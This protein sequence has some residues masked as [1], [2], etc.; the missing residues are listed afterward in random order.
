[1]VL[2]VLSIYL[3]I[4]KFYL[5]TF[6][7][8]LGLFLIFY[9]PA[10]FLYNIENQIE[11]NNANTS[12]SILTLFVIFYFAGSSF[13]KQGRFVNDYANWYNKP[14]DRVQ[15]NKGIL[16]VFSLFTALIIY[17]GLFYGGGI[18][19][20]FTV[21]TQDVTPDD[22][23]TLRT[24]SGVSGP[25][26][27]IFLY[28]SP[29]LGKFVVLLFFGY[30]LDSKNK[31]LIVLAFLFL[32]LIA[33][34]QLANLSKSG[35]IFF[36]IQIIFFISFYKNVKINLT[37][38]LVFFIF[39]IVLFVFIYLEVTVAENYTMALAEI[40]NRI[41]GEPTRV[42]NLY[43]STWPDLQNYTMG[44]N[45]RFAHLLFGSG[46]YQSAAAKLCGIPGCTYNMMFIGDAWVDFSYIGVI[47]QSFIVGYF[48]SYLDSYIFNSKNYLHQ[49]LFAS[50]VSSLLALISVGLVTALVTYGL[51]TMPLLGQF[52]KKKYVKNSSKNINQW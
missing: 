8:Y 24:E 37:K 4:N 5:S 27:D 28:L 18:N 35:F 2:I 17:L 11:V 26:S 39:I 32:A 25:V 9:G 29:G 19:S 12:A 36:I 13:F 47:T 42:L 45:I 50:L 10:F 22:I 6:N 41:F 33:I 30:S 31:L 16:F 20:I 38:V 40:S 44:M 43:T 49:A 3:I 34:S 1:M 15:L 7:I 14:Q 46:E 52:L 48:L 23:V 51:L 21:I